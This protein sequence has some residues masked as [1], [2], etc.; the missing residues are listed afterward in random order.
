MNS[1]VSN[2]YVT[3]QTQKVLSAEEKVRI[4]ERMFSAG[5]PLEGVM[6]E[7]EENEEEGKKA[8]ITAL[9]SINDGLPSAIVATPSRLVYRF[10]PPVLD[11]QWWSL[12][13]RYYYVVTANMADRAALAELCGV[14]VKSI[15][16]KA[17]SRKKSTEQSGL[18]LD[19][20]LQ[21]L[22]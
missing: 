10:E 13:L 16:G 22:D 6:T 8:Y 5:L 17:L 18:K 12:A 9:M 4:F 21:L 1:E 3:W 19:E 2:H 14:N 11:K 15:K 7:D 20:L